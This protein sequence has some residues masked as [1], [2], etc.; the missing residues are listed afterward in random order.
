MADLAHFE[1]RSF[2]ERKTL[3]GRFVRLEPMSVE[4]HLDGLFD[5]GHQPD[6]QERFRWLFEQPPRDRQEMETWIKSVEGLNDPMFF[7]VVDRSNGNACGRQALMRIDAANGVAEI[8]HI[9]WGPKMQR[10]AK[11]TEALYLFASYI[12]DTLGYRRFEWKCNN[13]NAPSKKAAA[14]F[15]FTYEG[16]FRQ[17]MVQKGKNRDTAWFSIVDHEWQWL[18]RAYEHWLKPDNFDQDQQQI[19]PLAAFIDAERSATSS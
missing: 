7:A 17:H 3:E 12:F 1:K 5:A 8:G 10:S 6:G 18:K 11:A 2:P 13:E 14:R 15:G 4:Q 19:K 16:L 9:Y